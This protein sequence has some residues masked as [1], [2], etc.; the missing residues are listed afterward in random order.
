MYQFSSLFYQQIFIYEEHIALQSTTP[1]SEQ[2]NTFSYHLLFIMIYLSDTWDWVFRFLANDR[3]IFLHMSH[4][5]LINTSV[6]LAKNMCQNL[7]EIYLMVPIRTLNAWWYP[8]SSIL[9]YGI[10]PTGHLRSQRLTKRWLISLPCSCN[11]FVS[12]SMKTNIFSLIPMGPNLH[13]ARAHFLTSRNDFS[14]IIVPYFLK[15]KL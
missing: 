10:P 1:S 4:I 6:H 14:V 13:H 2:G 9:P 3:Y 12:I 11:W 8:I 15:K 7:V 5:S